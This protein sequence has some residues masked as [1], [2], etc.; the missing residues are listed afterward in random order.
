MK[1]VDIGVGLFL[2]GLCIVV[3]VATE[4]YREKAVF[5]YGPHFFP[6]LLGACLFVLGVILIWNA[7]SG[8]LLEQK[9]WID[10]KGF[11]RMTLALGMSVVYVF[12]M[13]L[14][15]FVLSTFLFLVAMQTFFKY[16]S[17]MIRFIVSG[18]ITALVYLIFHYILIVP[19]P[20]AFWA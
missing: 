13:T 19:L 15:G 20:E 8:K 2:V 3:F 9:D 5:I 7:W 12:L 11:I 6:R 17:V 14:L 1:K 4:P 16:R 10:K 18:F